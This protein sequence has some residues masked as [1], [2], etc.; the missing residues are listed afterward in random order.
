V[1][2]DAERKRLYMTGKC[3][4]RQL[5]AFQLTK[6]YLGAFIDTKSQHEHD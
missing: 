4:G 6:F 2:Q 3:Y 5:E 1:A